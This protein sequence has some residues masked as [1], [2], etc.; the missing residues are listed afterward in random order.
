MREIIFKIYYQHSE[1]GRIAD[2]II[3]LGQP[4]P[5]LGEGWY[6]ID[7]CQFS[8]VLDKNK[9]KVFEGDRAKLKYHTAIYVCTFAKDLCA[10]VWVCEVTNEWRTM[11]EEA[12]IIGSIHDKKEGV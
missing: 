12:E 2:R 3:E 7:R 6:I 5:D 4:I 11:K 1:T 10:F 8:G 9:K